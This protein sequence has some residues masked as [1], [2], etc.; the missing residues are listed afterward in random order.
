VP[1]NSEFEEQAERPDLRLRQYRSSVRRRTMNNNYVYQPVRFFSFTF[2][3]T[4]IPWM[5]AAFYSYQNGMDVFVAV[6][7]LLGLLGPFI[8][9]LIMIYSSN[10]EKL[11][12]DY[13]DRLL[14]FR[15]IQPKYVPV[16]LLL[17]PFVLF[18]ST[19]LSLFLGR[20]SDQFSFSNGLANMMVII[21]LAPTFEELGW[22]GYG[23]DSLR[24]KFNLLTATLLFAVIWALWHAPL[25]VINHSYQHNVWNLGIMYVINFFVSVLPAAIIINWLYYKNNRSIIVAVLFHMMLVLTSEAFQTEQFTKCIVTAVLLLISFIIILTNKDFFLEERKSFI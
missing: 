2:L 18:L 21:I 5:L 13:W 16:I 9:A 17:L 11:K 7:E 10:N 15:R 19:F 6:F 22:R 12:K 20:S 3:L 4:W 1:S 23:M 8:A 25:F 14:N 24:S